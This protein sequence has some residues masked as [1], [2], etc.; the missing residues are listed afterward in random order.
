MKSETKLKVLATAAVVLIPLLLI[1]DAYQ[2]KK[3]ARLLKELDTLELKQQELI[4]KN[5]KLISDISLMSSSERI[6]KIA[7]NELGMHKAKSE[8]IVRVEIK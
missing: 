6:E 3:Y 7:E 4:E 8:D 2:A 5:R 1:L